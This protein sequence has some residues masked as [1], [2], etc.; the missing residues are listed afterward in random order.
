VKKIFSLFI[1]TLFLSV[2]LM[3]AFTPTQAHAKTYKL[4]WSIYVGWMPWPYA[5]QIRILNKWADKYGVK[6]KLMQA[7]Y[8]PTIESFVAGQADACVMTNMEALNMPAAGGIET[9][10]VIVGDFSNGNDGILMRKGSSVKDLKGKKIHLVELSVSH[11]LLVRA[12]EMNGMKEK[13]IRVV[14]TSDADIIP[15]FQSNPKM[16]C[17]VTWNPLLLQGEQLPGV[18]KIYDSSKIP[19]EIIDMLVFNGKVIKENPDVVRAVVGA[20]YETM[21]LLARRSTRKT[22]VKSMASIANCTEREF[23]KQLESTYLFT[24][25][26]EAAEF[27]RSDD[28]KKTMDT[29]RHFCFDHK[30]LGEGTSSVD[31]IGIKFPDKSVLGNKKRAALVFDA[32]FMEEYAQGKISLK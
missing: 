11:Y 12:L 9:V 13:D 26:K 5:E 7:D 16:Q 19:G 25:A 15:A 29:V 31:E 32:T 8:I 24:S 3:T 27:T 14:N 20:W 28:L 30:L 1:M 17:I 21:S 18:T 6:I 22:A 10:A 2:G 4:A 23:E